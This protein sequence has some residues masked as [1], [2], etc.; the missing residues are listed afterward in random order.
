MKLDKTRVMN[1][2]GAFR[3][4]R[5][6]MDSWDKSD[7]Y[8]GFIHLDRSA[9]CYD[10]AT[11]WAIKKFPTLSLT[12]E[13]FYKHHDNFAKELYNNGILRF[14]GD[15]AEVAYI[16]PDDMA[17]AQK[18]IRAGNEHRKFLR[19]IFISVDITA[20]IYIWKEL[21]TYKISTTANSTS[22]MHTLVNNPLTTDKFE[23]DEIVNNEYF[24]NELLPHLEDLRLKYLETKNKKYWKQ[25]VMEL[26]Q[27]FL[28]TRTWT[29]NYEVLRN[30]YNQRKG[31]KLKEWEVIRKWIESLPYADY[32][33]TI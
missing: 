13:E 2:E 1:F 20:P 15:I 23:H 27:S 5:N 33:I 29:A 16:G 8:F 19:Q 14:H 11:K 17:L 22:S 24:E 25:L 30:I 3:G 12:S 26:P 18:L 21:D 7:S 31:H 4:M 6:P 9:K 32:L 28:Q 10:I